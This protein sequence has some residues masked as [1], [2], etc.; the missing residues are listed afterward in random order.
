L[1]GRPLNTSDW[2]ECQVRA[3]VVEGLP[4]NHFEKIDIQRSYNALIDYNTKSIH[5]Y[6]P[7]A[8][9]DKIIAR[10]T[11]YLQDIAIRLQEENSLDARIGMQADGWS[12]K[13]GR[14]GYTGMI[15]HWID[16]HM[17]WHEATIGFT[18]IKADHTSAHLARIFT[19]ALDR[20]KITHRCLTIT[21]DNASVNTAAHANL[22]RH[23]E[24][25]LRFS[26][27]PVLVPC[28][29]HVIQLAQGM[30]LGRLRC[31]PTNTEIERDWQEERE[32]E[33]YDNQNQQ[34]HRVQHEDPRGKGKGKASSSR[35]QYGEIPFTLAKVCRMWW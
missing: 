16:N 28:L 30:I 20:I 15:I 18:P 6:G 29:S 5:F 33:D 34:R 9:H 8:L 4:L 7:T 25:T 26:E 12:A 32:K 23:L 19:E 13:I 35:E 1:N 22:E 31:S 14:Y 10:K 2:Q 11:K 3:V 17:K 27:V 21:A 24:D